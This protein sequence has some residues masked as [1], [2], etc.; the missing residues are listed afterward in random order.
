[1]FG[2]SQV[3]AEDKFYMGLEAGFSKSG[4]LD[5]SH[6]F[7][8]HPTRC[9]SLLYAPGAT[10]PGDAECTADQTSIIGLKYYF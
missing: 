7:V 10:P 3:S 5:I 2:S 6:S 1:M 9:D 4:D 8:N